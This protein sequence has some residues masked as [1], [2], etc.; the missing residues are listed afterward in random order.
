MAPSVSKL[1]T[2]VRKHQMPYQGVAITLLLLVIASGIAQI[3]QW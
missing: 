1:V 2:K 3:I